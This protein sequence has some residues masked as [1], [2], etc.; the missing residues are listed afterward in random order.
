M[1]EPVPDARVAVV[2]ITHNRKAEVISALARLRDLPERP[3]VVVVDNGSADGTADAIRT[4]H[5][6]AR[7][8]ARTE[9]LGA[10][11]RNVGVAE[12]DTPFV[13]FCDDDTWWEPGSLRRAADVFEA[14]PEVA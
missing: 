7:L 11:G 2:V 1:E 14:H 9:N 5:P 4:E 6:R 10:L 3:A 12:V 13:A 8:I